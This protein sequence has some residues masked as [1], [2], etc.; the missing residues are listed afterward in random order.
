MIKLFSD[1]ETS[2]PNPDP[3]RFE[4]QERTD[5][6]KYS[7]VLVKYHGCTTFGGLKLL[8]V[9]DLPHNPVELDPHFLEDNSVLARFRPDVQGHCLAAGLAENL[10]LANTIMAGT[11]EVSHGGTGWPCNCTW[12]KEVHGEYCPEHGV[13][14]REQELGR[15]D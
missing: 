2:S 12:S 13:K 3:F 9:R 10:Q 15:V 7:V 14:G 5:Y 11:G 4:I 1:G 8:L 6:G